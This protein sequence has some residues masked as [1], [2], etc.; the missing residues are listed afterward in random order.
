MK[1]NE[2]QSASR[3]PTVSHPLLAEERAQSSTSP[4][5]GDSAGSTSRSTAPMEVLRPLGNQ[6]LT[7][8]TA[9]PT[10]GTSDS[11]RKKATSAAALSSSTSLAI[12]A[13][14][15]AKSIGGRIYS[16]LSSQETPLR[17]GD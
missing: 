13:F 16:T 1:R 5:S 11:A 4:A 14:G 10:K 7:S 8:T 17:A 9:M 3:K 2:L 12:T 15:L 6:R